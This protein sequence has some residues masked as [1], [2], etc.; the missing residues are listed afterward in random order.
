MFDQAQFE[1]A[2]ATPRLQPP[3]PEFLAGNRGGGK[4][5]VLTEPDYADPGPLRLYPYD[6][7]APTLYRGAGRGGVEG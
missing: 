1:K 4:V 7:K 5:R 3:I 6:E 2:L